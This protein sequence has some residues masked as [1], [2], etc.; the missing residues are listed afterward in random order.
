MYYPCFGTNLPPEERPAVRISF[1]LRRCRGSASIST[2]GTIWGAIVVIVL[3]VRNKN[4]KGLRCGGAS[5]VRAFSGLNGRGD[6]G[7]YWIGFVSIVTA[8]QRM[9]TPCYV[10]L[11]HSFPLRGVLTTAIVGAGAGAL[12]VGGSR[13]EG[14]QDQDR[15]RQN[16]ENDCG[17]H[18]CGGMVVNKA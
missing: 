10:L 2:A 17:M 16:S 11:F 15:G 5:V 12:G 3:V 18:F 7:R 1:H 13:V 9:A 6:L 8:Y 4:G 14:R